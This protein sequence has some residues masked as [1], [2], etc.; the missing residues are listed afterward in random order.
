MPFLP[1][2]LRLGGFAFSVLVYS[3]FEMVDLSSAVGGGGEGGLER[4]WAAGAGALPPASV[5][6]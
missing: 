2:L 6:K 5:M 1:G 3:Y 4:L